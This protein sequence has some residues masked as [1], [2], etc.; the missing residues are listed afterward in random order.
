MDPIYQ[1]VR[2]Y[3]EQLILQRQAQGEMR[4]PAE[5]ELA[6]LMQCTRV[7]LREGLSRLEQEGRIYRRNRSGWFITPPRIRFD[8]SRAVSF[9]DYVL[10][11]GREPTTQVIDCSLKPAGEQVAESLSL[12]SARTP[13][14]CVTRCRSV[15]GYPV[16]MERNYLTREWCPELT[17]LA[18]SQSLTR[19]IEARYERYLVHSELELVS[20]SLDCETA[21]V[22]GT[23]V[24][25][26][27][28]KLERRC[29]DDAG[30][31]VEYDIEIWRADS[32]RIVFKQ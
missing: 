25:A 8:P 20:V 7:T 2:I 14:W 10:A 19:F 28:I 21:S 12:N 16:S 31:P 29:F 15:D 1:Q 5:R 22:L 11:Q 32:V 18:A 9:A 23:R 13:V 17:P 6:E 26:A 3:L 30:Q 4:L 27:G 24:G